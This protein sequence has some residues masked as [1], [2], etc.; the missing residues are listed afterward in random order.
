[1]INQG[2]FAGGVGDC[3]E[4][5]KTPKTLHTHST[6]TNYIEKEKKDISNTVFNT[7]RRI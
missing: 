1:M 3:I 6:Y 4:I 7:V 5:N 2:S